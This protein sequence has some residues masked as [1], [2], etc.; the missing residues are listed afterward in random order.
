MT[1]VAARH[2]PLRDSHCSLLYQDRRCSGL[3]SSRS[4]LGGPVSLGRAD[5]AGGRPALGPP[6]VDRRLVR[7][8]GVVGSAAPH[9]RGTVRDSRPRTRAGTAVRAPPRPAAA[10]RG[11]AG[12]PSSLLTS[13][14]SSEVVVLVVVDEQLLELDL[15]LVG[16]RLQAPHA[17]AVELGRGRTGDQHP[18]HDRLQPQVEVD[19]RAFGDTEDFDA[20]ICRCRN[21]PRHL[22]AGTPG[23][24]RARGYRARAALS[25]PGC[26][27]FYFRIP[28]TNRSSRSVPAGDV[29]R[30]N[31][32]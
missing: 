17:L 9:T 24:G 30:Q 29:H 32:R 27:G 12:R 25:G 6:R 10:A 8:V 20:Q 13:S 1:R 21:R 16:D 31:P 18:L 19:R 28:G 23:G 22:D 14:S 2:L 11:R 26:S 4:V 15:D 3:A 7:V 5:P